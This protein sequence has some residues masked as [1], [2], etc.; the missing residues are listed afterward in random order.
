MN[1]DV[2]VLFGNAI[3]NQRLKLQISQ[4]ELAHRS[5]LHPLYLSD[6]ER[7]TRNL[8][9]ESIA[10]LAAALELSLSSFFAMA[11][12]PESETQ[13]PEILLVEDN[14]ND[15]EMTLRA[16]KKAKIANP[17]RV[18]RDGEQA[19][20]FLFATGEYAAW[21]NRPLP[22][23]ILLDLNLPK[24]SGIEVLRRIKADPR[25]ASI[26]VIIL[27]VSSLD[28]HIAACR[29]L[30]V[31]NYIIKPVGFRNLSEVTP[32]LLLEWALKQHSERESLS[33][34]APRFQSPIAK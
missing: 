10:E 15:A 2:K 25:T 12:A 6:V 22:A 23:V 9:L 24:I 27:T 31:H 4:E 14:P 28:H 17:L 5:G 7:G 34:N 3:R 21:E 1:P 29:L 33:A 19:L 8:S 16:F 30:G 20:D 32:N 11:C 18:V 13:L 26:P